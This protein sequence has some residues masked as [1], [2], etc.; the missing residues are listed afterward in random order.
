[1]TISHTASR[2]KYIAAIDYCFRK[3]SRWSL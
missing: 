2:K 3:S 1:M